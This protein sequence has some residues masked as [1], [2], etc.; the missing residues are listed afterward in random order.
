MK[1]RARLQ[2]K[3]EL[4]RE[5]K[6]VKIHSTPQTLDL[7]NA[8]NKKGYSAILSEQGMHSQQHWKAV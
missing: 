3:E 7:N 5:E 6:P 2:S 4:L 1:L 8:M